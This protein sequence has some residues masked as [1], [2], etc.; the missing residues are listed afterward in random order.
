M[1][2]SLDGVPYNRNIA[3]TEFKMKAIIAATLIAAATQAQA[4]GDREQGI[5]LGIA[6]TLITQQLVQNSVSVTTVP[7]EIYGQHSGYQY[8]QPRHYREPRYYP[9]E[10]NLYAAPCEQIT[11]YDSYQDRYIYQRTICE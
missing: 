11:I 3:T 6:G 9:V 8:A 4:W 5:L 1:V 2:D 7:Q 10:R